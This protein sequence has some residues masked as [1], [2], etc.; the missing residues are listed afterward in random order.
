MTGWRLGYGVMPAEIARVVA[1]VG[2]NTYSC[3]APFVQLAGVEAL[4][5]TDDPVVAMIGEFRRRRD[6]IVDGLNSLPGVSCVMPAGAFY[7]FPNVS[8][9][10]CDDMRLASFILERAHVAALGGSCFGAA[11]AGYMR[12][13][14]AT[15]VATITA[16]VERIRAVLPQFEA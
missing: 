1:L 13:S 4:E 9:I 5:G 10:T 6:V 8:A 11:G 14:Y 12:F 15:S 16:A 2:Q 3:V 7:A